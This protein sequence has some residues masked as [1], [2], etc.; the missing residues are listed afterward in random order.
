MFGLV[1]ALDRLDAPPR[2]CRLCEHPTHGKY[3]GVSYLEPRWGKAS[4]ARVKCTCDNV[5]YCISCHKPEP[6]PAWHFDGTYFTCDPDAACNQ[7]GYDYE[8]DGERL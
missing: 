2:R 5:P 3:C 4:R 8:T 7:P 1:A 6:V